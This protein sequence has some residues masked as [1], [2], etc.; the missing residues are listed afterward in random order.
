VQAE[1]PYFVNGLDQHD[2]DR[3]IWLADIDRLARRLD[4]AAWDELV[5][6]C[7]AKGLA[8]VVSDGLTSARHLFATPLPAEA[9]ERLA[10]QLHDTWSTRYLAASAGGRTLLDLAATREAI[11]KLFHLAQ[12]AFPPPAY[13]R[14]MF[15]DAQ[16]APLPWLYVRYIGGRSVRRIASL[17]R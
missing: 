9:L 13:L 12:L 1:S 4:E 11:G 5:A 7:E 14:A 10:R 16:Q 2:P 6:L 3:M 8:G 15:P 17:W